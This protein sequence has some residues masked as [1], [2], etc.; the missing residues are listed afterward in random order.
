MQ[1]PAMDFLRLMIDPIG[2]QFLPRDPADARNEVKV[3]DAPLGAS[4]KTRHSAS[5]LS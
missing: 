5:V 2:S 4:A 3:D 1:S